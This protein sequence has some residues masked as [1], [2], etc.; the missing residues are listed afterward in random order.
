MGCCGSKHAR[1]SE[2][3]IGSSEELLRIPG[4]V[5]HLVDGEQSVHLA[6]G[7]FSLARLTEDGKGIVILGKVGDQLQWPIVKDGPA[8]KL[9]DRHYFFSLKVPEAV[10]N[11]IST[12]D[13]K[14]H[15]DPP[16]LTYGLT[17][18]DPNTDPNSLAELDDLLQQHSLFSVPSVVHGP[19]EV[20]PT[21]V[22]ESGQAAAD[23]GHKRATALDSLCAR[24]F[25]KA[26]ANPTDSGAD[27]DDHKQLAKKDTDVA[28]AKSKDKKQVEE[29]SAAYWTILAPNV[30]EYNSGIA[31]GIATGTG[32]VIQTI[33]WCSDSTIEK[34]EKGCI[35]MKG[36]IKANEKPVNISPRTLRNLRRVRKMTG[37][38][39]KLAIAILAGIVTT[40]GVISGA[41]IKSS[42]GQRFFRLLP[43]DVA[44]VSMDAFGSVLDA[45]EAAGKQVL[46]STHTATSGMVSH[47]FG[48]PAGVATH[49]TIASVGHLVGTAWVVT[50]IR[51][52]L[53]PKSGSKPT[54]KSGLMKAAGKAALGGRAKK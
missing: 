30:E 8:G 23:K 41:L 47:R 20:P 42:A 24:L 28:P 4:A 16:S 9:D 26:N 45:L 48:E 21:S 3:A 46:Y 6:T 34:L 22:S 7:D 39:E 31:K 50:K 54:T 14:K 12:E 33:F 11:D 35:Y 1:R 49:E 44:L 25:G 2:P 32:R 19:D 27:S 38:T 13:E 17:F 37:M 52:V 10:E 40:T 18:S 5:V 36:H 15:D 43:G 51:R 29:S 53:N